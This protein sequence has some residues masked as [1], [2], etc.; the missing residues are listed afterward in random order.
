MEFYST[1]D[2]SVSYTAAQAVLHGLA[3]DGGL[4]MPRSIPTFDFRKLLG[5]SI[6]EIGEAVISPFFASSVPQEKLSSIIHDAFNFLVPLVEVSDRISVLELFHGPT[7]AFKDFGARFLARII[8][9]LQQEKVCVLVATSGDTGSAVA[10]GFLRIPGVTVV[11]LYPRGRVSELQE[12]QMAT[13][14][15]N[16]V[17]LEVSGSFDDCQSLVKQAFLDAS[18]SNV[19]T[20]ASANS[21]NI[22]RL[23]PQSTFYTYGASRVP[24]RENIFVVPSGNFGNLTGGVIAKRMGTPISHLV[25]ATNAND[26]VPRY[27]AGEPYTPRPSV[28]TISNAMDVGS[29][30]N[31]ARL[32]DLF[33]GRS[34]TSEISGYA[35]DDDS[36]LEAIAEAHKTS[37]YLSD[38]HTAVGLCAAK[39]MLSKFPNANFIVLG[40]AHPGKFPETVEHAI[41]GKI[42]LPEPLKLALS[43]PKKSVSLLP[44]Y[45]DFKDFL[46]SQARST[47]STL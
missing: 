13:L 14:G 22:A 24:D 2:K 39:Q 15:E 9:E 12:Q 10:H 41:Q 34:M 11:L 47:G 26:V 19:L 44:N 23:I 32:L 6:A 28:L 16:I 46:L 33:E 31:F 1:K 3:P 36:C 27:L 8:P 5:K 18:L 35:V 7:F 21:I 43:K 38:P 40:T 45:S 29:P 30:N 20:L 25:A 4:F 17:A 42:D 37:G